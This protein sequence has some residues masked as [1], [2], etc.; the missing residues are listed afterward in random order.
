MIE[1][2]GNRLSVREQCA[3]LAVNKRSLYYEPKGISPERIALM[4][5]IDEQYTRTPFYGVERMTQ[6]LRRQGVVVGHNRLRKLLR[7][8]G[9]MAL[10]P[11]PRTSK[12][13]PENKIYPYL[14]RGVVA[15]RPNQVWSAD[16][17][18]IRLKRGFVYLV[19][20]LDW[21]SRYVGVVGAFD[22]AG[23]DVLHGG[24]R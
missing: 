10:C 23:Y 22:G 16:I 12:P 5:R 9:L 1:R 6:A 2:E 20:I 11:K 24:A 13:S 7:K 14:L 15:E 17:T 4:H 18:Y 3:L 19:A 21:Y 8:M